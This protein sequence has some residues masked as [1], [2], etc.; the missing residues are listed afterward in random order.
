MSSL[1]YSSS[2]SPSPSTTIVLISYIPQKNTTF[3]QTSLQTRM[4]NYVA[5]RIQATHMCILWGLLKLIKGSVLRSAQPWLIQN[6]SARLQLLEGVISTLSRGMR[7]KNTKPNPFRTATAS[8]AY[9]QTP[10][11]ALPSNKNPNFT[12]GTSS[13]TPKTPSS[14]VQSSL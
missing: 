3:R 6:F 8:S 9:Q 4:E 14:S 12:P 11:P 2:S 1:L 7:F 5:S 13:S 10:L